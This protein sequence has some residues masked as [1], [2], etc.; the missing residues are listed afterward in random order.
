MRELTHCQAVVQVV[1]CPDTGQCVRSTTHLSTAAEGQAVQVPE[2]PGSSSTRSE[3]QETVNADN[4]LP[5]RKCV[6]GRLVALIAIGD[7]QIQPFRRNVPCAD[8]SLP[9][10]VDTIQPWIVVIAFVKAADPH[11]KLLPVNLL[12]EGEFDM[13]GGIRVVR[14]RDG[15]IDLS[16]DDEIRGRVS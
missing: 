12:V 13:S 4:V 8:E 1:R 10:I 5:E 2:L 7:S 14:R 16:L 3:M 9:D 11:Q 6:Y 15:G